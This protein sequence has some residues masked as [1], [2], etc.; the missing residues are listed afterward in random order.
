MTTETKK[1]EPLKRG[2]RIRVSEL[3]QGDRIV[4]RWHGKR[5][6]GGPGDL[7]PE[8]VDQ[9][10]NDFFEHGESDYVAKSVQVDKLELCPQQWRTHIHVNK[11]D[12]YDERGF[13]WVVETERH[14][15]LA[16]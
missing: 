3:R 11:K 5:I 16:S 7:T 12:C 1:G 15:E 6:G 14:R 13:V 4:T 8:Q 9:V 2:I 10:V